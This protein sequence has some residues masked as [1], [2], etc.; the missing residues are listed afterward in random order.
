MSAQQT[1][2]KQKRSLGTISGRFNAMLF[3][4]YILSILVTLPITYFATEREIERHAQREL[5]LLVD[6]VRSVREVVREDTRPHFLPR[7]EIFPV[8][9]SSTV[10]AKTVAG[11]FAR[12]QPDYYIKIAS[13]NPLNLENLPVPMEE[14]LLDRFRYTGE[15]GPIVVKG[16][17]NG[18]T[19]LVSAAPAKSKDS[20]LTCHGNPN[21]APPEIVERY[22]RV[23]GYYWTS[24]KVVG[25]TVVGVPMANLNKHVIYD[26]AVVIGVLTVLFA[27]ILLTVNLIVRRTILKP[28]REMT[29]MAHKMSR[30]DLHHRLNVN[31]DDE[32][33]DLARSFELMRRSLELAMRNLKRH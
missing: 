17:V 14:N 3:M 15:E 13:D 7:G 5:N 12:L 22:G 24:G 4:F 16:V 6:M 27:A 11:K 21:L 33:G 2:R 18:K 23:N 32:I 28:L 9:I 20:C 8:V 30:G 26:S 19:Y 31:R 29:N 25:A 10:M 1:K